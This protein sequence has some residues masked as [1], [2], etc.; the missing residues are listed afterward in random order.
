MGIQVEVSSVVPEWH[1]L[2]AAGCRPK[3]GNL[4][5]F[6]VFMTTWLAFNLI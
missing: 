1:L 6:V 3:N 4:N 5:G 2:E